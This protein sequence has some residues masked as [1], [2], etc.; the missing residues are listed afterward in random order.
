MGHLKFYHQSHQYFVRNISDHSLISNAL[1]ITAHPGTIG[2]M[3]SGT[4]HGE[5]MRKIVL[6]MAAKDSSDVT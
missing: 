5:E 2:V 1:D 6:I 4:A 3:V